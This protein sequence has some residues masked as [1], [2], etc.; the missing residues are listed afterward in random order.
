MK[1]PTCFPNAKFHTTKI[2]RAFI[3]KHFSLPEP[4]L[5]QPW[6]KMTDKDWDKFEK[7][8]NGAFEKTE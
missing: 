3:K 7:D 8:I 4:K 6:K 2:G 5:S 1:E